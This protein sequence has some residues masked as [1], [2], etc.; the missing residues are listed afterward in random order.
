[1]ALKDNNDAIIISAPCDHIIP[2][3]EYF[4]DIIINGIEAVKNGKIVTFA[5]IS[6]YTSRNWIWLSKIRKK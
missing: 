1:M 5:N 3:T 4:N 6:P 2:D